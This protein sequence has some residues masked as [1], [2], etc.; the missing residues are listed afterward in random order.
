MLYSGIKKAQYDLYDYLFCLLILSLPYSLKLPNVVLIL[1]G[2]FFIGDYKKCKQLD[3]SKLKTKSFL[4]LFLLVLYEIIKGITT[5]TL[6]EN[7]Y[8]LLL[9][10][11]LLPFLA[12]KIKNIYRILFAIVIIGF[13][14]SAKALYG[15]AGNYINNGE[16]LPFEGGINQVL[17]MERPYL[18]FLSI[19]SIISSLKLAERFRKYR[20]LFIVYSL[21]MCLSI[22]LISARISAI[23][24]LVL[25]GIYSVFYI[26]IPIKKKIVFFILGTLLALLM[27]ISNKNLRERLFITNTIEQSLAK[28]N[29]HEPRVIIWPCAFKIAN[30][31]RF[32]PI[33]GLS[34]EKKVDSLLA[35]CYDEKLEN[36][37]RAA[38]FIE[39]KLNTHCQFIGIYISSGVIGLVLLLCFFI[40]QFTGYIRD[41]K[42]IA[43]LTALFLFFVVE[44]V[45]H[46]QLGI[47]FFALVISI[48]N[49]HPFVNN[50]RTF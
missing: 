38:F 11:V 32:N 4:I 37:N 15:I 13:L 6:S 41:F 35:N 44:N 22:F 12:L 3:F 28:L 25:I 26:N 5:S 33:F 23:T 10:V 2:L 50:R 48:I 31:T 29:R 7:K 40:S 1:L 21:Y 49:I 42:A 45:L 47:Y 17:G 14:T 43:L 34:S 9:P 46:R 19:V 36:K 30:S 8:T 24:L 39:S 20:F 18:G 27:I 16:L